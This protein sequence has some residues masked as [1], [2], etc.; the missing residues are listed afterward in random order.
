MDHETSG[1]QEWQLPGYG[2]AAAKKSAVVLLPETEELTHNTTQPEPQKQPPATGPKTPGPSSR[3]AVVARGSPNARGRG[4]ARARATPPG[5]A[6]GQPSNLL[7]DSPAK[8]KWRNGSKPAGVIQLP[9]PFGTFK[10]EFF[11]AARVTSF[12]RK[13]NTGQGRNEVFEEISKRTGAFIKPPAYSD[14][15][16]QLWGEQN[17]IAMAE[18]QIKAI[19]AKCSSTSKSKIRKDWTKINAY[20]VKKEASVEYKEKGESMLDELRKP[21]ELGTI[22]PEQLLFLWPKDGPPMNECLGSEL[23]FL[24]PIRTRF[25]CHLFAPKDI[26][27]YI[28]ALGHNHDSMKQVAQ[29]IRILWAESV[30]KSNI[31]AKIY[32]VEP[33]EP[34]AMKGKIVVEKQNQLHKP[35]LRGNRLKGRD[36]E[37]WQDRVNLVQ[38]RNNTRL[39]NAVENCLKGVSFVR[40][41]LRMRV[42]LGTFVLE[43][44]RK[45]EDEKSWYGFEEFREMLLHEQ[46]RG[47]LIPGLKVRPSEFLDRCFKANHLFEPYDS[48]ST[49]LHTADLAY[50]VNFEFLGEDKSMLRLEAE[51]SKSPGA[52]E[53]EIKERRWLRPRTGGQIG[54]KRPPLHV[55]VIDFGRSDWQ[56]EIK[57]LEFHETS[58]IDTALKSFSHNIAFR[59]TENMNNMSAKPERKVTFPESPPVSRLVEKSAIRYRMKGTNYIFEIARYDEYKRVEVPITQLGVTMTG[60]MSDVPY[61]SWGAS[62]F[63]GNW[64]NLLGGHANLPVGHSAKY[65]PNLATF[66]AP[67]EPS[68]ATEDQTKGFWEFIDLV[69]QAAKLLGPTWFSPEDT[70][71][72]IASNAEPSSL[73]TDSLTKEATS[74][75]APAP[76]T[77]SG[78]VGI[79]NADLGTLF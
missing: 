69:K 71:G 21:P 39:L 27:G 50:S 18:E 15:A 36:L 30:A 53:Y 3:N 19:I 54:D 51:F 43:N 72:D 38:S 55:A 11:G 28:C 31:R 23:E 25:G 7:R 67:R 5:A 73:K 47:R 1:A 58:S 45:P 40:G 37:D 32:L 14:Q 65:S 70:D 35:A 60:S 46:T 52:R 34:N 12:V 64:D 66:F 75:A 77:V 59:R 22:F 24:D 56:L 76:T 20:S 74:P 63:E 61:T 49:S 29:S 9:Y 62:V 33:P 44:Y 41:H 13:G 6:P 17:Q 42:N 10:H 48:T 8:L 78:P 68:P 2:R 26:P 79:L 57:S 4:V 16:I